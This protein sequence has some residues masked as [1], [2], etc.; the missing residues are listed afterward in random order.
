MLNKVL[1]IYYILKL[2][3]NPKGLLIIQSLK[4]I[5]LYNGR[6]RIRITPKIISIWLFPS[7]D[8]M[9]IN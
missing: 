3:L 9:V 2:N 7:W 1:A 4:P 5:Y 8:K 6:Y